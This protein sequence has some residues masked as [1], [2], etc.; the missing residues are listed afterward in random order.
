MID[1][2]G[3]SCPMPVVMV[4]K[5]LKKEA[6]AE[7]DVLVDNQTAME[8]VTR[9]ESGLSGQF[10][11]GR[12]RFPLASDKVKKDECPRCRKSRKRGHFAH[13]ILFCR[14]RRKRDACR[15]F[16]PAGCSDSQ[17]P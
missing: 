17:N 2:R 9:F 6:P 14:C 3:F 8:N 15:V 16:T 4:Q 12:L 10:R 7:L 5:A 11:S 13:R 1:A